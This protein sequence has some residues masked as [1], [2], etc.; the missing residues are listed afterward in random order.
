MTN[1]DQE[2]APCLFLGV[3]ER[4]RYWSL[5]GGADPSYLSGKAGTR[6]LGHAAVSLG[7]PGA[8]V[9][10]EV[11]DRNRRLWAVIK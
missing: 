11:R 5:P 1:N 6:T 4:Q 7:V 9:A 2:L 10:E 3:T 8:T